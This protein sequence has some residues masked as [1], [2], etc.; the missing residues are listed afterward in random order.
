MA[1]AW[2]VGDRV[3]FMDEGRIIEEGPPLELF[4]NPTNDRTRSFL[5][6][7][8]YAKD[9]NGLKAPS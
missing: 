3:F 5:S 7:I 6:K 1:F 9:W 2:E 8:L 4:S